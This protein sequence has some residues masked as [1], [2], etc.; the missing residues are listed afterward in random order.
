MTMMIRQELPAYLKEIR[1]YFGIHSEEEN[2]TEKVVFIDL[3]QELLEKRIQSLT[4]TIMTKSAVADKNDSTSLSTWVCLYGDS[5]GSAQLRNG[6]QVFNNQSR[7]K[8]TDVFVNDL[9]PL[10]NRERSESSGAKD[11]SLSAGNL[12]EWFVN[13][14]GNTEISDE[15]FSKIIL[16]G[17]REISRKVGPS[18]KKQ[19][20]ILVL[21]PTAKEIDFPHWPSLLQKSPL[22][23]C[24]VHIQDLSIFLDPEEKDYQYVALNQSDS[25]HEYLVVSVYKSERGSLKSIGS[26]CFDLQMSEENETLELY[27]LKNIEPKT[28]QIKKKNE[29]HPRE[30]KKPAQSILFQTMN[31]PALKLESLDGLKSFLSVQGDA[32]FE[33][34]FSRIS[35][36]VSDEFDPAFQLND[37]LQLCEVIANFLGEDDLN[38]VSL[39]DAV[40]IYDWLA[41]DKQYFRSIN[42]KNSTSSSLSGNKFFDKDPAIQAMLTNSTFHRFPANFGM[43]SWKLKNTTDLRITPYASITPEEVQKGKYSLEDILVSAVENFPDDNTAYLAEEVLYLI[44]ENTNIAPNALFTAKIFA[45][46]CSMSQISPVNLDYRIDNS[47]LTIK[48][49][50]SNAQQS[51][52]KLKAKPKAKTKV[53]KSPMAAEIEAQRIQTILDS[54][55]EVLELTTRS[56]NTL[57]RAGIKT[58]GDITELSEYKLCHIRNLGKRNRL[59]IADILGAMGL[60]PWSYD[61]ISK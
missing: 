59:E 1:E 48:R 37:T 29:Q 21:P 18:A 57:K 11:E 60:H 17:L 4:D 7:K 20:V 49:E 52:V 35:Q 5:F 12:M 46:L 36:T 45:K 33:E 16:R 51:T 15:V 53:K 2:T 27:E 9:D 24:E 32:F 19:E 44:T 38:N 34:R 6:N 28:I 26:L 3:D 25:G 40:R 55:I 13:P 61:A 30:Q 10:L 54:P 42:L 43:I 31:Y 39:N 22:N 56:Y 58:V 14:G 23:N 47:Y 50:Q 8:Q 41:H